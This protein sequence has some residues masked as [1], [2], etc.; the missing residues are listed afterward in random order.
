ME[1]D[2]IDESDG[3]FNSR[4]HILRY[5]IEFHTIYSGGKNGISFPTHA[6]AFSAK[7]IDTQNIFFSL[8]Q[9]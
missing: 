6:K 8:K 5:L 3:H 9:I 7:R 1:L 2:L 4:V